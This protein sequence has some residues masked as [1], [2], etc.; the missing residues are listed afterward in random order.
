MIDQR[1]SLLDRLGSDEAVALRRALLIGGNGVGEHGHGERMP[2]PDTSL[3]VK[4]TRRSSG[5]AWRCLRS[6]RQVTSR[7]VKIAAAFGDASGVYLVRHE[8]V[9]P[10][11]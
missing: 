4:T 2:F 5:G 11:C 6:H 8:T 1:Y 10:I 3:R 9:S 7:M